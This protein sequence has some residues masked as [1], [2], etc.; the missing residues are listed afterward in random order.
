MTD[1]TGADFLAWLEHTDWSELEPGELVIYN[2]TIE[3]CQGLTY[4]VDVQLSDTRYRIRS[5]ENKW[6]TLN[7]DRTDLTPIDTGSEA[8]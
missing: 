6:G 3:M 1:D 2:G 5:T 8:P 7:A 4:E